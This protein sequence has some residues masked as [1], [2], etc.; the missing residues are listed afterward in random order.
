MAH[1]TDSP[2]FELE[3]WTQL[4]DKAGHDLIELKLLVNPYSIFNCICTLNHVPDWISADPKFRHL[5]A[6]VEEFKKDRNIDVVRQL[7]NRAKHFSRKDVSPA[8]EV[9]TGYGSGRYGVGAYG[10][11]EPTYLVEVDGSM[12]NVMDV[13]SAAHA[14]WE[15]L[16]TRLLRERLNLP[17]LSIA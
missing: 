5:S 1:S 14:K 2:C 3:S 17:P 4:L 16:R 6:V 9:H 10:V 12:L 11:G 15:T 13:L 8:T 7:C